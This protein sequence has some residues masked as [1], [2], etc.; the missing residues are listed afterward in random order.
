MTAFKKRSL[1]NILRQR[2]H[3]CIQGKA[4][5]NIFKHFDEREGLR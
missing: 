1:S 3:D 2:R 5:G 4:L